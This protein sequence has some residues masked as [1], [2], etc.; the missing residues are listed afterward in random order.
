MS[1]PRAQLGHFGGYFEGKEA[2]RKPMVEPDGMANDFW[3]EAVST[4]ASPVRIATF[5]L[6]GT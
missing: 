2:Q 1:L 6:F 5:W 3:R 4:I